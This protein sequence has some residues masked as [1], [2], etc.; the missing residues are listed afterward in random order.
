MQTDPVF[1]A[2][3][4]AHSEQYE[5]LPLGHYFIESTVPLAFTNQSENGEDVEVSEPYYI[6]SLYGYYFTVAPDTGDFAVVESTAA[7]IE[8]VSLSVTDGAKAYLTS[9]AMMTPAD[10]VVVYSQND[11]SVPETLQAGRSYKITASAN[12]YITGAAIDETAEND[13]DSITYTVTVSEESEGLVIDRKDVAASA[14]TFYNAENE[15]INI[16]ELTYTGSDLTP[17]SVTVYDG[18]YC[19]EASQDYEIGYSGDWTEITRTDGET[20]QQPTVTITGSGIYTGTTLTLTG[21]IYGK[22][23][24]TSAAVSNE[25]CLGNDIVV[26]ASATGGKGDYTYAFYFKRADETAWRVRQEYEANTQLTITPGRAADYHIVV[27]AKDALGTVARKSMTVHV[28]DRLANTSTVESESVCLGNNIVVNA[29]ATGGRGDYTYAFYFKR[30]D[31]TAW[32][33]RQE[34]EPN[35]QLIITPG[36]VDHHPRSGC[37]L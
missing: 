11:E 20:S 18:D 28:Y 25:V 37:R 16:S 12:L 27:K 14:V 3:R 35:A 7:N 22:L 6:N 26:N 4:Y 10:P 9:I 8:F 33:V 17:A 1:A 34:Y 30:S 32:R 15:E 24:N 23:V 2:L 21:C 36:T 29:S 5:H 13:D 19:L 31:E